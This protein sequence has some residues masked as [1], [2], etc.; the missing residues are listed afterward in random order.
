M[1]SNNKNQSTINSSI[2]SSTTSPLQHKSIKAVKGHLNS[3][4]PIG[5]SHT[6]SP[7]L[8][9]SSAARRALNFGGDLTP[10]GAQRGNIHRNPSPV[11][12]E[13]PLEE[14]EEEE[15]EGRSGVSISHSKES[16]DL[17]ATPTDAIVKSVSLIDRDSPAFQVDVKE[18]Q[19]TVDPSAE[20]ARKSASLSPITADI[21]K[22]FP[23][24][25][26]ASTVVETSGARSPVIA[27][28]RNESPIPSQGRR[29][30]F[31]ERSRDSTHSAQRASSETPLTG[32][33]NTAAERTPTPRTRGD[34]PSLPRNTK[35]RAQSSSPILSKT[36]K[37]SSTATSTAVATSVVVAT[38]NSASTSSPT[39]SR[40]SPGTSRCE[41]VSS[42]GV[43]GEVVG[44]G[45][46]GGDVVSSATLP[47]R[48]RHTVAFKENSPRGEAG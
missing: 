24:N 19:V 28:S 48:S 25:R 12:L 21:L 36:K 26:A 3:R 17:S 40:P 46:G 13:T 9:R 44:G 41:G 4:V 33:Q 10:R 38:K 39:R 15:E 20:L 2:N 23:R 1:S 11:Q 22:G 42:E 37:H 14:E 18:L 43:S 7:V 27:R 16:Q 47:R 34:A 29:S 45:G 32:S 31:E 6:D 30:L 5:A 8:N 35:T